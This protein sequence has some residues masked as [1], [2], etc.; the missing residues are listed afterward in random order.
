MSFSIEHVFKNIAFLQREK[1]ATTCQNLSMS[2]RL[3]VPIFVEIMFDGSL[4]VPVRRG[5]FDNPMSTHRSSE[6]GADWFIF[7]EKVDVH[8]IV[9]T[10]IFT[11]KIKTMIKSLNDAIHSPV[12]MFLRLRCFFLQ[13][14]CLITTPLPL[15]YL[16]VTHNS[17]LP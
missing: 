7:R 17:G 2:P 14:V 13:N 1:F 6:L 8:R 10:I 16:Q 3:T 5:D 4:L 9:F 15:K 12:L 11:F